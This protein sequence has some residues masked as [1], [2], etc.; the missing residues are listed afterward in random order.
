M[1]GKCEEKGGD[2]EEQW[3]RQKQGKEEQKRKNCQHVQIL[4]N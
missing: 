2:N 1:M 4:W 3:R